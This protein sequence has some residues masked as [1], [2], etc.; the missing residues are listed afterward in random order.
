MLL[1][2]AR[3][4]SSL[5]PSSRPSPSRRPTSTDPTRGSLC[6]QMQHHH[7]LR[8]RPDHF[9]ASVNASAP[10]P[11]GLARLPFTVA[12]YILVDRK[13]LAVL[14]PSLPPSLQPVCLPVHPPS[15]PRPRRPSVHPHNVYSHRTWLPPLPPSPSLP[16]SLALSCSAD[17]D[18]AGARARGEFVRWEGARTSQVFFT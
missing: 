7:R 6:P 2:R 17:S 4:L 16:P 5:I 15:R 11:R 3:S 14:S 10:A 1:S 9:W 13:S 8:R 18:L 12:K